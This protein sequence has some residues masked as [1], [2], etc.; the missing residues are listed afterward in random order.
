MGGCNFTYRQH[1]NIKLVS[2]AVYGFHDGRVLQAPGSVALLGLLC[3]FLMSTFA[4]PVCRWA[5][6]AVVNL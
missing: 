5:T 3:S 2:C 6:S 4:G 1:I